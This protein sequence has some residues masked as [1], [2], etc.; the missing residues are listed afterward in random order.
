MRHRYKCVPVFLLGAALLVFSYSL[1]TPTVIVEAQSSCTGYNQCP[2]LQVLAKTRVQAPITYWFDDVRINLSAADAD[3]FKTHLRAAAN[4]WAAKTG[5][6]ITETS[7]TTGKV[8][9]ITSSVPSIRSVN[10]EAN[11]TKLIKVS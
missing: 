6:S 3:D 10:G 5:I 9:I 4:D 7:G 11:L 8:R 1:T 2:A